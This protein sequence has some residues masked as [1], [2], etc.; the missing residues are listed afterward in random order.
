MNSPE[1]GTKLR[2]QCFR[3]SEAQIAGTQ[4]HHAIMNAELLEN[5]FRVANKRFELAIAVF[6]RVN[7]KS[8]TF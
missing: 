8:S 4:L 6:G 3:G 7:L 5:R 2:C 1:E